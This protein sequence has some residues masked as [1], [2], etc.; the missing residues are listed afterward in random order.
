[1]TWNAIPAQTGIH[2]SEQP[3]LDSCMDSAGRERFYSNVDH[4]FVKYDAA[5]M[6]RFSR[7]TGGRRIF[8]RENP[9]IS[10]QIGTEP[11]L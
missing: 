1:M 6:M 10:T 3:R 5:E 7:R 11:V 8:N 4:S 9:T 2:D